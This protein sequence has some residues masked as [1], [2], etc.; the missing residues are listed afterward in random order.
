MRTDPPARSA[1]ARPAALLLVAALLLGSC[2]DHRSTD[3]EP[4][5]ATPPTATATG[6][7]GEAPVE[8]PAVLAVEPRTPLVDY[9]DGEREYELDRVSGQ[10][11]ATNRGDPRR[12]DVLA[13]GSGEVELRYRTEDPLRYVGE[14]QLLGDWVAFV[15]APATDQIAN[16]GPS[17][18][19]VADLSRGGEARDVAAPEGRYWSQWPSMLVASSGVFFGVVRAEDGSG[20]CVVRIDQ[21]AATSELLHCLPGMF[22][23]FSVPSPGGVSVLGFPA[24]ENVVDCRE[25]WY[26]PLV[27]AAERI[28]AESECTAFDGLLVDGWQVW[29]ALGGSGSITDQTSLIASDP[30]GTRYELGAIQTGSLRLCGSDVWWYRHVPTDVADDPDDVRSEL[31]RWRPG[32]GTAVIVDRATPAG[33]TGGIACSEGIVTSSEVLTVEPFGSSVYTF[34]A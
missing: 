8:V 21:E 4:N 24:G 10:Y 16:T 7:G 12:L 2:T 3:P 28:A 18:I 22:L 20:D 1:V 19:K 17:M 14:A 11:W 34:V 29:T 31:I 23:S 13:V 26:V 32:D 27:G 6:A 5:T 33:A 30:D 9:A 15:D 25:R